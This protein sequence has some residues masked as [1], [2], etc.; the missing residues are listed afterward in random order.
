MPH[1]LN[2]LTKKLPQQQYKIILTLNI[3]KMK[4]NLAP[5]EFTEIKEFTYSDFLRDRPLPDV[6]GILI[7]INF[8]KI[9][10]YS[11]LRED[12]WK[13]LFLRLDSGVPISIIYKDNVLTVAE[14]VE[15]LALHRLAS[16]PWNVTNSEKEG[17]DWI[18]N[19]ST[20]VASIKNRKKEEEKEKDT[21]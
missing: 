4:I 8:Q 15:I 17:I 2:F 16:N 14:V 10:N 18:I 7:G 11:D 5:D 6:D 3:G 21:E 12:I 19:A 20:S 1:F 9:E 13:H